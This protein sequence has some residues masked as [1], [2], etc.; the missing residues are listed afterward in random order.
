MLV[1][2]IPGN[3]YKKQYS[4]GQKVKA[5]ILYVDPTNK[6]VKLSL[7]PELLELTLRPLPAIGQIFQVILCFSAAVHFSLKHEQLTASP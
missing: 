4:K 1:Q 6:Q 2:A 5:R 3:D 7:Q